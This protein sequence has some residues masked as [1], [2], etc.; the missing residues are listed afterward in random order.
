MTPAAHAALGQY[1]STIG[2]A[3][4]TAELLEA[5]DEL[6]ALGDDLV[7]IAYTREAMATAPFAACGA[8]AATPKLPDE[9][10]RCQRPAGHGGPHFSSPGTFWTGGGAPPFE[11]AEQRDLF[12]QL[13]KE[14]AGT[15]K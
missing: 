7:R 6:H 1:E 14:H 10:E 11:S 8:S 13:L 3:L 15:A 5:A 12:Y 4:T 2:R 9:P